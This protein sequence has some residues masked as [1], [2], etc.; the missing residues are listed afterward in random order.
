MIKKQLTMIYDHSTDEANDLSTI[1]FTSWKELH[2]HLFENG[3]YKEFEVFDNGRS[4]LHYSGVT[5]TNTTFRLYWEKSVP[6]SVLF[7]IVNLRA[8]AQL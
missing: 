8:S 6:G 1:C 7:E 4:V 5:G 3:L 2:M